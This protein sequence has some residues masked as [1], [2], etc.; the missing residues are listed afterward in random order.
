[1]DDPGYQKAAAK[2]VVNDKMSKNTIVS[3][4][5]DYLTMNAANI[6]LRKHNIGM[7]ER[8][9]NVERPQERLNHR[10]LETK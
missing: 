8:G 7:Q 9:R 3:S 2:T 6:Q 1:M 5:K 10:N 4:N